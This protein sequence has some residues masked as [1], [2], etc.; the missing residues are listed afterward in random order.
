MT[1]HK[2]FTP[3]KIGTMELQNR[4]AMA[5][6]TLGLESED[7]TINERLTQ[8]WEERAKGGVGLII[9]DVVTVDGTVPYLGH[10][11]SLADDKLIPSFRNFTDRMHAHGTKVIPQ[12]SHPGPESIS[13]TFGVQPVGP[14]AYPNQFG[15]MVRELSIEEIEKIIGLY[16][17]A[18]RR[19]KSAGFDGVELHCAHAYMLAGS[20]LSPL[21]N[22]RTD[23]YGGG[24]DGRARFAME[25]IRDMKAKAGD[26]F[27]IIMRI[28]G[29]ERVPGG[30]TL[31]DMLYLIP[32]FI[33]AGADGFEVSG[34]TQYEKSWKLIPGHSE[35]VG[36]NAEEASAI[37]AVSSVPVIVVGKIND[38]RYADHILV[39]KD[40]DGV[41]MGRALLADS[42]LPI[43]AIEG[44]YEDIAPCTGCGIGCTTRGPGR[45]TATCVINPTIGK[46][47]AMKLSPTESPKKVLIIG[48]G[49]AG[50]EAARV[51]ALRGH[52]VKILERSNKLGGQINIASVPPHKQELVKWIIYLTTQVEKLGVT[53]E[54]N[55]EGTLENIQAENPDKIIIATGAKPIIPNIKGIEDER[56][57]TGFDYLEGKSEAHAGNILVV[58]GGMVGAE[59]A[60]TLI[61]NA[62]GNIRVNLVEMLDEIAADLAPINRIPL[63]QRLYAGGVNIST[64]TKVKEISETGVIVTEK[65]GTEKTY[66]NIDKIILACGAESV[67]N[68]YTDLK[69]LDKEIHLIGDAKEP[70]KALEAIE[71]GALVGR[72]I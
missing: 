3:Y 51:S 47:E 46:E 67:N 9:V 71:E 64:S 59:I 10:T 37:K 69:D 43:K 50:L 28:S 20:F 1:T 19:A 53:I 24:L 57:I 48:G 63:I 33:E 60:E 34:G 13:W 8:F 68:L 32:K 56:V 22:K 55:T 58:G 41:V 29:D 38:P 12:I 25:I 16:G 26:D 72:A 6:M 66:H 52:Q 35:Q 45:D 5:P 15:K 70:R 31:D 39:D 4:I 2:L 27:P 14:S 61:T 21:R 23:K 54:Y 44:K 49:V 42:E 30:N 40:L 17:D 7:G 11:I 65:D 36:L 18:A 62:R